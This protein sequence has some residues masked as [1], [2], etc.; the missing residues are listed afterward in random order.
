MGRSGPL[1][2]WRTSSLNWLSV[3]TSA[4]RGTPPVVT[5]SVLPLLDENEVLD[6]R[7]D[8]CPSG[9]APGQVPEE[10]GGNGRLAIAGRSRAWPLVHPDLGEVDE[11]ERVRV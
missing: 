2:I 10:P 7:P 5:I 6:Q 8:G 3:L 1:R 4:A 11:L 9:T